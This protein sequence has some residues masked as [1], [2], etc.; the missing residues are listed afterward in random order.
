MT[1]AL[2]RRFQLCLL[3]PQTSHL[4]WPK[5]LFL[6]RFKFLITPRK[7]L[8]K[9]PGRASAIVSLIRMGTPLC[10]PVF[11]SS[12]LYSQGTGINSLHF[13]VNY[14]HC[15][16]TTRGYSK[17]LDTALALLS[18]PTFCRSTACPMTSSQ[19]MWPRYLTVLYLT[20][21]TNH[22]ISDP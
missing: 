19:S 6:K 4:T 16:P 14:L 17:L 10:T 9:I 12:N 3:L 11:Y 8:L 7:G 20:K 13:Q 22:V 21:P 5:S 2:S 15:H 1:S 18:L